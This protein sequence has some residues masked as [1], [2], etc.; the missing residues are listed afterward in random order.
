[1]LTQLKTL[2]ERFANSTSTEDLFDSVNQIYRDADKDPELKNWFKS[3][4]SYIRK[5]LKDQGFIMQDAANEEW[6]ALYDKGHFL[7]RERYREHT[8]RILDEFKFMSSQFEQDAQNKAFGNAMQKLFLDLGSDESGKSVFKPHLV[9]D[10][11][12]IIIPAIFEHVRYIPI[13]RIEVSDP[14]IDAVVENLVIESDN[15]MPNALEFSSDN[16]FRWGRKKISN[17]R[18]NAL[19][20]SASGVQL[21]LRD[22]S[23]YIKKKQGFPSITDT[24][25]MDVMLGG[26][27]FSFKIAASTAH[28]NDRQHFAKVDKVTVTIKHLNIKVKKSNHKLLF[29]I[30]KPILLTVMRPAIQKVL[31]KQIAE[32]F[33]KADAQAFAIHQEAQ[34]AIE[35]AKVDPENAPTL[36]QQYVN[37]VQRDITQ[38]K[39]KAEQV[40]SNTKGVS[41]VQFFTVRTNS[42]LVNA[43][44][45]AHDSIFQNIKLEGGISTKATEFKELAAKG[46]KWESPVFTIGSAKES[47]D[48]P[49]LAAVSRKPHSTA[50]SAVRGSGTTSSA[51]NGSYTNGFTNEVDQAFDRG[52]DQKELG[53]TNGRA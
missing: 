53:L 16:Y 2:I 44:V 9:K 30:A 3:I 39:A 8:N 27:G 29:G 4:D 51:P 49:K 43:A 11:S 50:Q 10:L 37:A 24:G 21:D 25:I 31:E 36:Y 26:E 17:K 1:M 47:T 41:Y 19:M 52:N 35:A 42:F 48:I 15:L 20:I 32:S 40:A 46:D 23:Y 5:C 28:K 45:T 6:Q 18:H 7:L 33:S 14:M 13:P 38:R 22:V 34:K 12:Q